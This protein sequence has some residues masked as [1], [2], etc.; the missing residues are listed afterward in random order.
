MQALRKSYESP[1][2]SDERLEALK[3]VLSS[4]TFR[5]CD[6][7]RRFLQFVAERE[8]AGERDAINEY[9]IAWNALSRDADFS[10]ET[11][12]SVRTRAHSLRQKLEEYNNVEAG[13]GTWRIVLPKGSYIP[14]FIP[15]TPVQPVELI[16][17]PVVL[18]LPPREVPIPSQAPTSRLS[19]K[20]LAALAAATVILTIAAFFLGRW[21]D[22]PTRT[23]H[24]A[25]LEFW[26]PM[27]NPNNPAALVVAEP[28]QLW[29]RNYTGLPLPA[30]DPPFADSGPK[31][32]RFLRWF[33]DQAKIT[34]ANPTLVLHPSGHSTLWG[35]SLGASFAAAFISK[36]RGASDILPERALGNEYALR[37]RP[38][39]MF[40]RP[41]FSPMI[42]NHLRN[43]GYTIGYRADLRVHALFRTDQPSRYFLNSSDLRG[44]HYGLATVFTEET[45]RRIIV[46]SGI[47]ADGTQGAIEYLLDGPKLAALREKM[48]LAPND[49]W[50]PVFQVVLRTRS[51][52]AY[53]M[54]VDYVEH[55][56][57][58]SQ[59]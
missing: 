28:P 18:P 38:L 49:P 31:S 15:P 57:S 41:E 44:S 50:P 58:S 12:S 56:T 8:I 47:F 14:E 22:S 13:P 3:Q 5:R 51:A 4:R 53:T 10:P 26:A 55:W 39:L 35:D 43:V 25:L 20:L 2:G 42:A 21:W 52:E 29:V 9:S 32:E 27:L 19:W 11:D 17:E 59:R 34:Q 36:M 48:K 33:A 30:T 7:L 1:V 23:T 46:C 37:H 45:G 40:G 16:P 54:R 6:Q 24:P